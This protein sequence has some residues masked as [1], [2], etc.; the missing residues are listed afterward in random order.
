MSR[1]SPTTSVLAR[2]LDATESV[3]AACER[4]DAT[5]EHVALLMRERTTL[6]AALDG[7]LG[8]DHARAHATRLLE[9]DRQLVA[10][11]DARQQELVAEL[12]K[13]PRTANEA[14]PAAERVLSDYA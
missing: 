14:V 8:G 12:A 2:V 9:L 7:A 13:L 1:P 5:P 6:L 11:C 4:G 10:W 3:W